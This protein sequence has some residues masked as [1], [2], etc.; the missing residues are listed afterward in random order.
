MLNTLKETL[1]ASIGAVA[2]K[3]DRLKKIIEDMV[4]KGDLTA[5]QGDNLFETL[6]TRGR[7]ESEEISSR[8]CGELNSMRELLPVSRKEFQQLENRVRALELG[9]AVSS[10]AAGG[11]EPESFTGGAGAD[12]AVDLPEEYPGEA[13]PPRE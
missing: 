13:L 2:F 8:V 7:Q 9:G 3:K 10:A 5:D 6:V 1:L 4:D 11:P 12:A